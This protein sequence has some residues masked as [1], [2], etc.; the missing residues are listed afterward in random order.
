ME[1]HPDARLLKGSDKAGITPSDSEE[2]RRLG[3][4]GFHLLGQHLERR[5]GDDARAERLLPHRGPRFGQDLA[6][7]L[8]S[9][10]SG[11]DERQ[12]AGLCYFNSEPRIAGNVGHRSLDNRI[13]DPVISSEG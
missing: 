7:L 10:S 13:L 2:V 1:I 3:E 8:G 11:R 12:S 4:Y 6:G 9:Q 5:E